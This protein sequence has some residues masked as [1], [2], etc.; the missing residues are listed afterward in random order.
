MMHGNDCGCP[1][2]CEHGGPRAY[3]EARCRELNPKPV[4][5]L[6][7]A[8]EQEWRA[9]HRVSPSRND[10][11]RIWA[12]LDR[13]RTRRE[14]AERGLTGETNLLVYMRRAE[15]A[16]SALARKT[17]E[18]QRLREVLNAVRHAANVYD[19]YDV[20]RRIDAALAGGSNVDSGTN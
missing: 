15:A 14:E 19:L 18:C 20:I 10:I 1:M 11:Q 3:D 8:K 16:E 17:E 4:E 9:P 6:S 7:E 5:P 2:C 12:T 13:E